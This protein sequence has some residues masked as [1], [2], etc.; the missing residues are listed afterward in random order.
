MNA[1]QCDNVFFCDGDIFNSGFIRLQSTKMFHSCPIQA[2]KESI[3]K[4]R[5]TKNL[6][7]FRFQEAKNYLFP[8]TL[9]I[10]LNW[11][12]KHSLI[13]IN[14]HIGF[15]AHSHSSRTCKGSA[16]LHSVK[17]WKGHYDL[18]FCQLQLILCNWDDQVLLKWDTDPVYCNMQISD[19]TLRIVICR[20]RMSPCII[21]QGLWLLSRI[22]IP[23]SA[24]A[25]YM[26]ILAIPSTHTR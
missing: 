12:L 4:I 5:I 1:S 14:W 6:F 16:C 23:L 2:V 3:Q 13:K 8:F 18:C 10:N 22:D 24:S 9:Y 26:G 19:A 20:Y 25:Q 11:L 15:L 21:C 17:L 7:C